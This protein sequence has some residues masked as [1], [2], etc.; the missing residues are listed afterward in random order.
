MKKLLALMLG[1]ASVANAQTYYEK[2][3]IPPTAYVSLAQYYKPVAACSGNDVSAALVSATTAAIAAGVPLMVPPGCYSFVTP[4]NMPAGAVNIQAARP[5]TVTFQVAAANV[6]ASAGTMFKIGATVTRAWIQGITF[7]GNQPSSTNT[8]NPIQLTSCT[9]VIFDNDT[10]INNVSTFG[11]FSSCTNSGIQNSALRHVGRYLVNSTTPIVSVGNAL[12]SYNG[13]GTGNWYT[14]N[15]H[16]DIG[17]TPVIIAGQ[18]DFIFSGNQVNGDSTGWINQT[19]GGGIAAFYS[20]LGNVSH[21]T[22]TN[23]I[24][25]GMTGNGLDITCGK[26]YVISGNNITNSG[27]AGLG[28]G[29]DSTT[30][31]NISDVAVGANVIKNSFHSQATKITTNGTTAAGSNGTITTAST[32]GVVVGQYVIGTNITAGAVVASIVANTSVTI[33]G[34]ITGGGVA[35]P[36]TIQFSTLY[37]VLPSLT[38]GITFNTLPWAGAS[39]VS[40]VTVGPVVLTDDQTIAS[41]QYGIL[42]GPSV[43][44]TNVQ[45]SPSVVYSGNVVA[46]TSGISPSIGVTVLCQ[47]GATV[48]SGSVTTEVNLAVCPIPPN[49]MGTNGVLRI[50]IAWANTATAVAK[51]AVL[52]YSASA[53]TPGSAFSTASVIQSTAMT[54]SDASAASLTTVRENNATNSQTTNVSGFTP[55]TA[56]AV[57]AG[58]ASSITTTNASYINIDCTDAS[59][60]GS[61]EQCGISGYTVELLTP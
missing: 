34:T 14:N 16:T 10:F 19:S 46:K 32:A 49:Y 21:V 47:S 48:Q 11:G 50:A 26:G 51:T 55:Y 17:G 25:T 5:G 43:T 13:T 59:S 33:T 56:G 2:T 45:V 22:V 24:I 53:G 44:L 27:G 15:I 57:A 36:A 7:D 52:R 42:V 30:G 58:T 41:Q 35:N 20:Q 28:I 23:N 1:L 31:C 6:T 29:G 61:T 38:G 12:F 37:P 40:N 3:T 54:I 60:N 4:A 8:S 18:T 39:T 9:G